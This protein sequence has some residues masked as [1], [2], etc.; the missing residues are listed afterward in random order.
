MYH[1]TDDHHNT[2][3]TAQVFCPT[4]F[5]TVSA[6]DNSAT[7]RQTRLT[8]AAHLTAKDA[9]AMD[10]VSDLITEATYK[11]GIRQAEGCWQPI[12]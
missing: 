11:A 4:K 8:T 10:R 5:F 12:Y 1:S 6:R 7:D 2:R 9:A 3:T